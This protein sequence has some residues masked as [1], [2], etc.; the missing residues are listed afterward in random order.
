MQTEVADKYKFLLNEDKV[1]HPERYIGK[2]AQQVKATPDGTDKTSRGRV[3]RLKTKAER[4]R[5]EIAGKIQD[6][7]YALSTM[8]EGDPMRAQT[9]KNLE[10]LRAQQAV[11]LKESEV[12]KIAEETL[13]QI[14][15][16][17]TPNFEGMDSVVL[18]ASDVGIYRFK[19]IY[20]NMQKIFGDDYALVYDQLLGPFDKSKG[21]AAKEARELLSEE[22]DYIVKKLGI[23]KG[24]REEKAVQWIGEGERNPDLKRK[25]DKAALRQM[26][27][28][29]LKNLDPNIR[30]SYTDAELIEEFGQEKAK[31]IKEAAAWYRTK[32]DEL[33][34]QINEVRR[35]IYPNNPEK[36]MHKRKDYFRHFREMS[37]GLQG[38]ANIFGTD[39]NIDPK[40]AGIS[41]YTRPKEKWASIKQERKGNVTD[42]G[43]IEG[44]HDS[45]PQA[46]QAIYI[47]EHIDNFG[48]FAKLMA[49]VK[50]Q[51]DGNGDLNG[52]ILYLND[53]AEMLAGKTA[54]IDRALMKVFGNNDTGRKVL[55]ALSWLD[56][57]AKGNMIG[58][59]IS[60]ILAQPS[61]MIGALAQIENPADSAKGFSDAWK[62]LCGDSAMRARSNE[63]NFLSERY[64]EKAYDRFEK[65]GIIK[66]AG[67]LLGFS[68]EIGTRV[69]WH[70]YYNEGVRKGENPVEYA[71]NMTRQ[72]VA[73]RGIGEVPL[74]FQSKLG[75]F[76][77]P[78]MIEVQ[79]NWHVIGD[80][81]RK[82]Q[83]DTPGKNGL[84]NAGRIL[85]YFLMVYLFNSMT[86]LMRGSKV[87]FDPI[88]DVAEGVEQG[89][90]EG[91]TGGEKAKQAALRSV[92]NLAGDAISNSP[93][94]TIG[95]IASGLSE[96]TISNFTNDSLYPARGAVPG[97]GT[98]ATAVGKFFGDESSRNPLGGAVDL[99]TT[100][101]TPFG[102][103]QINKTIRGVS[104]YV[105]GGK[106]KN[107]IY[108]ELQSGERGEKRYAI[109]KNIPNLL[110]S[111]AFGPSSLPE[112]REY[113]EEYRLA[114]YEKERDKK[115]A[116][117]RMDDFI[118]EYKE[119]PDSRVM[120]VYKE[121]KRKEVFPYEEA[122]A[123]IT[124][125]SYDREFEVPFD[126][127][128]FQEDLLKR[129]QEKYEEVFRRLD[130][131]KL[132]GEEKVA[133]FD[134]AK[135]EAMSDVKK[136][137]TDGFKETDAE[138][139]QWTKSEKAK[140]RSK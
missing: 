122:P 107:D 25:G 20:R 4:K 106:Y 130:Y 100:Y 112:S 62:D 33:F 7:E 77:F 44:F 56:N 91:R 71:D 65:N 8:D 40:L 120:E 76:F 6:L 98:A 70:A 97:L 116:Q 47:D 50:S 138:Y 85:A 22:Y 24:S 54:P 127:E 69:S 93:F 68:D 124:V 15:S 83:F 84:N 21:D 129:I 42:E 135:K 125:T 72:A 23:K 55:K 49:D 96:E 131:G 32:Y 78:F 28:V 48:A 2:A 128:A 81:L 132:S 53:F 87:A 123:V 105:H 101:V 9:V 52:F 59:N 140:R 79:N 19:S 1:S 60:T 14:D 58:G 115:E 3:K 110:R 137:V 63:S 111:A 86:E 43:A 103:N 73:G 88:G 13:K 99:I 51:D 126:R 35:R 11:N 121:T 12:A 113:N 89:L 66:G 109:E 74:G 37:E 17:G 90:K 134:K 38:I 133:F 45:L 136:A 39:A 5:L 67:K 64:L 61:N 34:D 16:I 41:E 119:N 118:K 95:Q 27:I 30:L 139:K 92:Q 104:D 94:G 29:N 102:G 114:Q 57:R 46:M 18:D 80:I 75:R 31:N 10:R 26:G 36:I 117:E 82:K 108:K